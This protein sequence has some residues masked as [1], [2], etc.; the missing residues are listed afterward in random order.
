M[1]KR[2][3]DI[4]IRNSGLCGKHWE[5]INDN[6]TDGYITFLIN[7][8]YPFHPPKIMFKKGVMVES[9]SRRLVRYRNLLTIFEIPTK[10][11]HCISILCGDNWSA[12]CGLMNI[13]D[14]IRQL[15]DIIKGVIEWRVSK[16]IFNRNGM[17]GLDI[18][19]YL[20]PP[21]VS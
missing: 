18:Y 5:K 19:S 7:S 14:E 15:S 3:L 1:Y 21:I 2:R 9:Y 4:E 16:E 20:V 6:V 11:F 13:Y 8:N 12:S 10:C 17:V